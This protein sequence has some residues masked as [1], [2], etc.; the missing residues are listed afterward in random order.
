MVAFEPFFRSDGRILGITVPTFEAL[1]QFGTAAITTKNIGEVEASYSL[2]FDCSSGVT[3]MEEQFYIMKPEE[4]AKRSFKLYLTSDQAARYA[5]SAILKDAE[6][7]E[8]DRA[9]CVFT[10]TATVLE[11]GSQIPFQPP[12]TSMN[13]FFASIEEMWNSFWSGLVDFI[14]G[15]NCRR[16][17][18]GFFNFSCHIQYICLSWILLFG[19]F[20]DIFPTA[21]LLLW[22]L[23]QKG[24]F[25]PI[26]DWWEDHKWSYDQSGNAW[27]HYGDADNALIRHGHEKRHHKHGT[28]RRHIGHGQHKHN[29]ENRYDYYLHHVHKDKHRHGRVK[30]PGMSEQTH[31]IKG[32]HNRI[33]HHRERKERKSSA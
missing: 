10:T 1:T 33:R 26:Y 4:V 9:E 25:D 32:E 20:L 16:Q 7:K 12:K 17:C 15:K 6:F 21:V 24:L 2:A 30:N 31:L 11:N 14:T 8:V 29:G 22:L 3:Q 13:G 28:Q 18:S 5:C 27:K 23:H 19:L